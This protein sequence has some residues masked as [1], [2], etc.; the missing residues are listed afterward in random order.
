MRTH[1]FLV[2]TLALGLVLAAVPSDRPAASGSDPCDL[3]PPWLLP[4]DARGAAPALAVDAATDAPLRVVTYNLHSGLGS[5][6]ALWRSRRAVEA[7][8]RA[9]AETI[10]AAAPAEA[11]VDVVALNE[12]DFG[13]RRSGNFDQAAFVADALAAATG[14]AYEVLRGE[15]W[16]R[17]LP[18]LEVR[19]G[20]ALLVRHPVVQARACLLDGS[21][22]CVSAD[23]GALPSLRARGFRAWLLHEPRGVIQATVR[24]PGGLVDVLATHLDAFLEHEREAQ[25][26]VLARLVEPGRPTVLLGDLNAVPSVLTAGRRFFAADRTHDVLT[27]G[28]LADV[29]VAWAAAHGI[30]SLARWATFPAAHPIWPLDAVLAS[31]ELAADDIA[32]I[33]RTASDHRGLAVTLRPLRDPAALDRARVRHA[34]VRRRQLD[35][36]LRCDLAPAR[37]ARDWLVRATGFAGLLAAPPAL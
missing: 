33:G 30:A 28:L 22:R 20:N 32:V 23:D 8:L 16:R 17:T 15:T 6:F 2:A 10:L 27:S 14:H 29:R 7:N 25:G 35:R 37:G 36:L 4:A 13:S 12:V 26:A 21:E 5:R 31:L 19:F 18:G 1:P 9:V 11:P 34:A 24:T 3:E